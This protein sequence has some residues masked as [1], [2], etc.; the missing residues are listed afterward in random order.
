[1]KIL[2]VKR[3][4]QVDHNIDTAAVLDEMF[5]VLGKGIKDESLVDY[6][7]YYGDGSE[8]ELRLSTVCMSPQE[9]KNIASVLKRLHERYPGDGDVYALFFLFK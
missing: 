4:F 6:E 7:S 8:Y 3:R 1:M 5:D 2:K 9:Y